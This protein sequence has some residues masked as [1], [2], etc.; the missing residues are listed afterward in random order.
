MSLII[1]VTGQESSPTNLVGLDFPGVIIFFFLC[2][3]FLQIRLM[4]GALVGQLRWLRSPSSG[5]N[6]LKLNRNAS[7]GV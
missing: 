3:L 5:V 1:F 6:Y 7:E 2:L 4:E